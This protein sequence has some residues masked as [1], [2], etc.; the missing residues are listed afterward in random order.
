MYGSGWDW[1]SRIHAPAE[2]SFV[3]VVGRLNIW[4][5]YRYQVRTDL[6]RTNNIIRV[7]SFDTIIT[8]CYE[9]EIFQKS[10]LRDGYPPRQDG[11]HASSSDNLVDDAEVHEAHVR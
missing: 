11:K 4:M 5:N 7:S 2:K 3:H 8:W 10:L 6:V 9:R 1:E